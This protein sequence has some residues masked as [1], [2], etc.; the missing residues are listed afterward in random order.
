[1]QYRHCIEIGDGAYEAWAKIGRELAF[2]LSIL[3]CNVILVLLQC[4]ML[5]RQIQLF[6]VG[7]WRGVAED[8]PSFQIGVA[9]RPVIVP[10]KIDA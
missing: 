2:V 1:M 6:F 8:A 3:H 4:N 9:R 10:L 7:L 5:Y